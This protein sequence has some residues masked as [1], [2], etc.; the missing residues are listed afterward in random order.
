MC[1]NFELYKIELLIN[2]IKNEN[3]KN[4]ETV[5]RKQNHPWFSIIKFLFIVF[6]IYIFI[7]ILHQF[8]PM[9]HQTFRLCHSNYCSNIIYYPAHVYLDY[10]FN[11]GEYF[12]ET[13]PAV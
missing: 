6:I 2:E 12:Y 8:R 5:T 4:Q 9:P 1:I 3:L 11:N 7:L 13:Y 10:L